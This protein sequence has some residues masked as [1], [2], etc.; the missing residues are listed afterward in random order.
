M[1]HRETLFQKH[2]EVWAGDLAPWGKCLPGKHQ[3]MS[4]I[5]GTKERKK[6]MK[7]KDCD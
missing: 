5:T 7:P 6:L 4:L 1:I 3:V 2:K